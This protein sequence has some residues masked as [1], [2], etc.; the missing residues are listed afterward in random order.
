MIL[1]RLFQV[2]LFSNVAESLTTVLFFS[3]LFC[4]FTLCQCSTELFFFFFA[5][6]HFYS[7][8]GLLKQALLNMKGS[9]ETAME[10]HQI[11]ILDILTSTLIFFLF[12]HQMLNGFENVIRIPV[13]K[14]YSLVL[15][16][17]MQ[18]YK[19]SGFKKIMIF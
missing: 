18:R 16:L 3:Y 14:S 9:W 15:T 2:Q 17:E 12:F 10:P 13:N 4:F 11:A 8:E 1:P 19:T 6:Y 5:T 7:S